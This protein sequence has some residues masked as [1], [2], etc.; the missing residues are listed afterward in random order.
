MLDRSLSA[1]FSTAT[2]IY[3][4]KLHG[5][6]ST[7]TTRRIQIASR[8]EGIPG[9]ESLGVV[10]LRHIIAFALSSGVMNYDNDYD[11][12][13]KIVMH[14][15]NDLDR[16][17][18]PVTTGVIRDSVFIAKST[19]R[20][21]EILIPVQTSNYMKNLP[22]GKR[23]TD[24]AE[25]RA[26]RLIDT[27]SRELT[28]NTYRDQIQFK[29]DPPSRAVFTVDTAALVLQYAKFLDV[30][31]G[32]S[33]IPIPEYLH[34]YV[35]NNGLLQDLQD[36]WLRSRYLHVLKHPTPE[37]VRRQ[38]ITE[39][40]HHNIYGYIGVQYTAAME[41]VL[42]IANRCQ[43][44]QAI[45]ATIVASLP[46]SDMY[47]PEYFR[48]LQEATGVSDVRQN[49]WVE[50]LRDLAWL[51]LAYYAHRLNPNLVHYDNF[52]RQLKRDLP[53]LMNTRF[54][55]TIQNP[56]LRNWVEESITSK[57]E[58]TATEGLLPDMT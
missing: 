19:Q 25:A 52:I 11:R 22:F 39:S 37:V 16:L 47:V 50:Y 38:D 13:T 10:V 31:G 43:S 53:L 27:D 34:K 46:L 2:P 58:W 32:T 8:Y 17:I 35:L 57:I 21:T 45:P 3:M 33:P 55:S 48:N 9:S 30:N 6:V 40:I 54:W 28:F 41:D 49:M 26:V 12:Y 42:R 18:D 14:I 29:Q 20:C 51:E 23:W 15:Q 1:Y 44:G 5:Y 24:W 4:G 7:L 56:Q 36:I